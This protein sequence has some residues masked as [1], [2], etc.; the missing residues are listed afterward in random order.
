MTK[1]DVAT[2]VNRICVKSSCLFCYEG[3][4]YADYSQCPYLPLKEIARER[5]LTDSDIPDTLA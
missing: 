5:E 2:K 4:K 1:K 3:D